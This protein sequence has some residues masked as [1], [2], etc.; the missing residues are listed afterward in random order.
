[1][2]MGRFRHPHLIRGTVH[3]PLGS[4]VITRGIVEMPDDIGP[5]LGWAAITGDGQPAAAAP[6]EVT[7]KPA[8]GPDDV[9]RRR[10]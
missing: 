9:S 2:A 8:G 1:M 6:A 10:S 7:A 5:L 4:F 3:T